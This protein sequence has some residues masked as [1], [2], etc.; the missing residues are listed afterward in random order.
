M[1][2]IEN[3]YSFFNDVA[4]QFSSFLHVDYKTAI[5]RSG[6]TVTK[7]QPEFFVINIFCVDNDVVF[8]AAL[9]WA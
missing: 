3:R 8:L 6:F 2:E 9:Q 5:F 1:L 7:K 4:G